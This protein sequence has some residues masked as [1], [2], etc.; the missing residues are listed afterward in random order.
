MF[1]QTIL[2]IMTFCREK[3]LSA[4]TGDNAAA[5][6]AVFSILLCIIISIHWYLKIIT[7]I[8]VNKYKNTL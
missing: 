4:L 7:Y 6:F 3:P 2:D 1:S 5:H 8:P